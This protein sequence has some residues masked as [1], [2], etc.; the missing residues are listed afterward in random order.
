MIWNIR[1][2]TIA[3]RAKRPLV[4]SGNRRCHARRQLL[5]P[6]TNL[7]GD[8]VPSSVSVVLPDH[9]RNRPHS[10]LHDAARLAANLGTKQYSACMMDDM[11]VEIDTRT[12]K[13]ARYFIVTRGSDGHEWRAQTKAADSMAS[14]RMKTWRS[15]WN[16]LNPATLRV[17]PPGLNLRRW[18]DFMACKCRARLSKLT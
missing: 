16:R 11:L 17:R 15:G 6:S 12:L 7:H 9:D 1:P 14:C 5:L 4:T 13:V 10:N 3:L 18:F 8:M 2:K